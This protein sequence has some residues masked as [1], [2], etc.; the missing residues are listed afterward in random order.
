[1]KIERKVPISIDQ[2]I[3]L[4]TEKID[5]KKVYVR[6]TPLTEK[7]YRIDVLVKPNGVTP[8]QPGFG[9][10]TVLSRNDSGHPVSLIRDFDWEL[11]LAR[12]VIESSNLSNLYSSNSSFFYASNEQNIIETIHSFK[13]SER[14]LDI[15]T[16][17]WPKNFDKN[18]EV[19]EIE[20]D[21]VKVS[22]SCDGEKNNLFAVDGQI[23][24]DGEILELK[25]LLDQ[26]RAHK[27]YIEL[28]SSNWAY[29]T[30]ELEKKLREL[31]SLMER[32]P[33]KE[34][35][36]SLDLASAI[37]LADLSKQSEFLELKNKK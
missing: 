30:N 21:D 5:L 23:E 11:D 6:F 13:K 17:E 35:Q 37:L 10:E 18:Y 26:L 1:M 27:R 34:E 14:L 28:P 31:A 9:P 36:D 7:G 3:E 8:Y 19:K 33:N 20:E 4:S 29:L 24:I 32:D 12:E 15:V 16:I 22:I 2:K 25:D